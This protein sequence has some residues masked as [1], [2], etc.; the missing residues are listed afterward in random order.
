M[1]QDALTAE[2]LADRLEY[3]FSSPQILI[4][5]ALN[6]R[7]IARPEAAHT[8]LALVLQAGGFQDAHHRPFITPDQA[9]VD[10]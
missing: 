3:L 7:R 5:A 1:P 8:L 10:A 9:L 4:E 2:H 6:A